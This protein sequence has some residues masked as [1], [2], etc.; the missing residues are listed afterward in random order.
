MACEGHD[1]AT[2]NFSK[3]SCFNLDMDESG[4]EKF[5]AE[6]GEDIPEG[7]EVIDEEMVN[8]EHLN[9]DF[10]QELNDIAFE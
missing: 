7:Y 10:E 4:L 9:F 1:E 3:C 8:G 2:E 6:Y 5:I